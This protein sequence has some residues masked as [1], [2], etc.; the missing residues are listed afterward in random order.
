M[1]APLSADTL[2]REGFGGFLT[3]GQLYRSDCL[4]VP[5]EPGVYVVLARG[6]APHGFR[7]RS[8][9]PPWRGQDPTLS[10]E[11]LAARWIQDA[12]LLYVGRAPGPGV[13]NRLRQRIKRFLRF[14]HGRV[15]A[16]WS[17]R[18][19]WQLEESSRLEVAWRTCG[20]A[21]EAARLEAEVLSRFERQHG[22]A[23]YANLTDS[24]ADT[25]D[26]GGGA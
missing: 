1:T 26:G 15:V 24:A 8:T 2:E 19:I 3:I 9:A 18:V 4:E 12:E 16:H 20:D 6:E 23:P 25:H 10:A 11:G 22:A 13:R 5:D 7:S 17:G 21:E 14:G